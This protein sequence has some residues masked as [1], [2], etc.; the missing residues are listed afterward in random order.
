MSEFRYN[1]KSWLEIDSDSDFSIYNFPFGIFKTQEQPSRV[2]SAYGD[3]VIDLVAVY[4][5]GLFEDI[6][7]HR[8]HLRNRFLNEL[9]ES[10]KAVTNAIQQNYS[11]FYHMIL[12]KKSERN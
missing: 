7:V 1:I 10:G 2:C 9:I 3:F 11:F 6:P 4:D 8:L 5:A 12:Q